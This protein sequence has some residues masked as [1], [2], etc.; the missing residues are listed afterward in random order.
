MARQRGAAGG[1]AAAA[2]RV[3]GGGVGRAAAAAS[4]A[5]N[6]RPNSILAPTASSVSKMNRPLHAPPPPASSHPSRLAP[7]PP[8]QQP[9]AGSASSQSRAP[10]LRINV[11]LKGK[12]DV[13]V[14]E[15]FPGE[16]AD[17]AA[18]EFL[19]KNGLAVDAGAVQHLSKLIEQCREKRRRDVAASGKGGGTAEG[20]GEVVDGAP[21]SVKSSGGRVLGRLEVDL[22]DGRKRAIVL[23]EGDDAPTLVGSFCARHEGLVSDA[24]RKKITDL[25]RKAAVRAAAAN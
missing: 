2:T 10:E 22:Q 20:G 6:T 15:I 13:R 14:L 18:R 7:P 19:V 1:A 4:A 25:L 21:A 3:D 12:S 17:D 23:R 9:Q 24:E 8:P 11:G 5:T 16:S